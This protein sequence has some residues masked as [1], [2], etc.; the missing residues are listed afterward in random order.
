MLRRS[1]GAKQPLCDPLGDH[2]PLQIE[3]LYKVSQFLPIDERPR[4][5]QS[6]DAFAD[7]GGYAVAA[8]T[9]ETVTAVIDAA[10]ETTGG[11]GF[12]VYASDG[13]ALL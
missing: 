6:G 8:C 1:G 2:C 5:L 3:V 9:S 10:T 7:F 12:E 13:L 11:P 4:L